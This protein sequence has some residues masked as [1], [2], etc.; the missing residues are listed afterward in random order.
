MTSR[1][2]SEFIWGW[3]FIL[4]TMAGLIILNIFPI[5]STIYQSFFKTGD[6][7]K[8][9]IFVGFNNYAKVFA[10]TEV[11]QAL[12]NTIKYAIIY[13]TT[14]NPNNKN[15]PLITSIIPSSFII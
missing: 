7:G 12:W 15:K 8:G 1:E 5:F 9:N 6:F 3:A 13:K 4:P 14:Q 11:W 2:K 10:D